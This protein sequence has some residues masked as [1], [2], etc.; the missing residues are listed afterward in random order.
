MQARAARRLN[1]F[2]HRP[3]PRTGSLDVHMGTP[4]YHLLQR[5]CSFYCGGVWPPPFPSCVHSYYRAMQTCPPLLSCHAVPCTLPVPP[6]CP[7]GTATPHPRTS[8]HLTAPPVCTR[9]AGPCPS[10]HRHAVCAPPHSVPPALQVRLPPCPSRLSPRHAPP[11]VRPPAARHLEAG[12]GGC[13]TARRVQ[14]N[15]AG[16][17]RHGVECSRQLHDVASCCTGANVWAASAPFLPDYSVY[18]DYILFIISVRS[19][20]DLFL[21]ALWCMYDLCVISS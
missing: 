9:P 6:S 19:Q 4:G 7:S 18:Y 3:Y 5:H 15:M 14:G 16:A 20:L 17:V 21:I 10:S 1:C 12:D 13:G 11:A 8:P 2:F